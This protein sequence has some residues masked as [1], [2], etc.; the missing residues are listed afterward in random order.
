MAVFG[1]S[2]FDEPQNLA[3]LLHRH[4][5]L[6]SWLAA[7]GRAL[8]H[9]RDG[10]T[11]VDSLLDRWREDLEVGPMVG[12][13]VGTYLGCVVV[14]AAPGAHW[15]VWPNGQPVVSVAGQ[16][17]NVIEIVAGR[18]DTGRPRLPVVL[19]EVTGRR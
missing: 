12:N 9:D 14:G 4:E 15:S 6:A 2:G 18:L 3:E 8:R 1:P 13:E 17:L 11:E 19:D 7:D 16:E 5:R 10:L